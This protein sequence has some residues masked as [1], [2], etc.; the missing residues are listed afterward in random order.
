MNPVEDS[1]ARLTTDLGWLSDQR[2]LARSTGNE[3]VPVSLASL[4]ALDGSL[5]ATLDVLI[6]VK[7]TLAANTEEADSED[8]LQVLVARL[9]KNA[10]AAQS[11]LNAQAAAVAAGQRGATP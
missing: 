6:A 11:N 2:Y 5:R 1:V 3:R 7:E 8:P 9:Q 10:A 4:E